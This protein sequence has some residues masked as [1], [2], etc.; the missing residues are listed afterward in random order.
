MNEIFKNIDEEKRDRVINSA[1]EEFSKSGFDKASTNVI[2]KNA[3]ISKG[4]LFHYFQ[5]KQELYEKLEEFMIET[6]THAVKNNINWT[7]TD[8]FER[9]KQIVMSKGEV[10]HQ[11]PYIYDF[12]S[13][14]MESKS[15]A[16]MRKKTE[17]VSPDLQNKV[18]THNID[19]SKFKEGLDMEKTMNII[20]W[21]LEKFSEELLQE[22]KLKKRVIDFKEIQMD[23]EEY[24]T[25]LKNMFYKE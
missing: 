8:F 23:V 2:V 22:V 11:Y 7:E 9:M 12:I 15:I 24:S 19:F 10:M 18:Y 3:G 16:E 5:N 21:T 20:R 25:F 6:A 13:M 17:K 14:V 1:L 4:S